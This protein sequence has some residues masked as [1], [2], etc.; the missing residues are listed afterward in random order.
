VLDL[1]ASNDVK[2]ENDETDDREHDDAEFKH[3]RPTIRRG[4]AAEEPPNG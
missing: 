4:G 1:L 3:D 2:I